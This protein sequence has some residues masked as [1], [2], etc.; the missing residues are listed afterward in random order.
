MLKP[1]A[2]LDEPKLKQILI[3][4]PALPNAPLKTED[5]TSKFFF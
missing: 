1:Q 4:K 2:E 3:A 5:F